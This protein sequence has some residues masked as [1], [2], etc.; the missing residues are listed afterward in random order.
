[1]R[2][3]RVDILSM[4]PKG[5]TLRPAI[6]VSHNNVCDHRTKPT[7]I[8]MLYADNGGVQVVKENNLNCCINVIASKMYV[9]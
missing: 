1:M 6:V 3:P 7:P 8:L 5:I 9:V 4:Q 2:K